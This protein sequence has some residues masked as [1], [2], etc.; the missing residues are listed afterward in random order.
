MNKVP[1]KDKAIRKSRLSKSYLDENNIPHT[2][3]FCKGGQIM[4]LAASLVN[5]EIDVKGNNSS[6][7]CLNR[8]E[9][10]ILRR[11]GGIFLY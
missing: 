9:N 2:Q 11:S 10:D 4:G 7:V 1:T 5:Q 6:V 8:Q 3:V